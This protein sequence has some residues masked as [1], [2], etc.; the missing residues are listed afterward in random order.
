MNNT[1]DSNTGEYCEIF[2]NIFFCGTPSVA[3]SDFLSRIRL[4]IKT[5]C[6]NRFPEIFFLT[7]SVLLW[8]TGTI[9]RLSC[10]SNENETVSLF[11]LVVQMDRK[12]GRG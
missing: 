6:L 5:D 8:E 2:K 1:G 10:G 11:K 9:F 7:I 4:K 12:R 3:T